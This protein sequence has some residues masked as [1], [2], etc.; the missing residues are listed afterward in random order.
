M[1]GIGIRRHRCLAGVIGLVLLTSAGC[2]QGKTRSANRPARQQTVEVRRQQIQPE[3]SASGRVVPRQSVNISPKSSGRL[4]ELYVDQGARVTK[5]QVIARMDDREEQ[6]Q[7]QQAKANLAQ[8]EARLALLVAG[9]RAEDIAQARAQVTAAKARLQLSEQRQQQNAELQAQGFV[10]RDDLASTQTDRLVLKAALDEAEK[11]L[12][13]ITKGNRPEEIA[14]ARAQVAQAKAQVQTAQLRVDETLVRAPFA[15]VITQ[16]YTS[17]GAFVTPTTSASATSSATSS[18]IVALAGDLEVL[19]DV[20]EAD[21]G[22]LYVGQPVGIVAESFAGRTFAGK[23]RL[24]APEAIIAQNVTSFEVRVALTSG[25][26]TL[27]SGMS[28]DARFAGETV[29]D[30]LVVPSVSIT[31]KENQVGVWVAGSDQAPEFRPVTLGLT[32]KDKTQ[33]IAGLQA[34]ERVMMSLPRQQ[35]GGNRSSGIRLFGRQM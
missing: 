4:N 3:I 19:V 20:P 10:S 12:A 21:L 17:P 18:S 7:L 1:L 34:G 29:A 9:N 16:K 25:L 32:D 13:V 14:Q 26:D 15:G 24:I 28:V 8:A 33:V 30:A 22:Q 31:S 23:V 6:A 27:R 5:G 11:R 35:M 2:S